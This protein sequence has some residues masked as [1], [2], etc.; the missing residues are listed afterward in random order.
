M[1]TPVELN[2]ALSWEVT[3]NRVY[4]YK[5]KRAEGDL[6][7]RLNDFPD[8]AMYTLLKNKHALCSFNTWPLIWKI[9]K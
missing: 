4:P 6:I 3:R 9:Q 7:I 2:E 8:E 1:K 5:I